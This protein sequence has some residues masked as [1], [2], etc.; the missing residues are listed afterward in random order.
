MDLKLENKLLLGANKL[1]LDIDKLRLSQLLSYMQLL[2]KWNK[3]YSLTAITDPEEVIT[4]HL[5][6][7]LT[8]VKYLNNAGFNMV[9][10][11][12]LDVGS[13]M[14]IPGIILA[15]CG[16]SVTVL[17]SNHKKTSFLS[18][19]KIELGLKNL[20]VVNA[21][22]ENYKHIDKFSIVTS[23][24]FAELKLFVDLTK[25]LLHDNGYFLAMK[26][27]KVVEELDKITGYSSEIIE[28]HIPETHDKRFLV[29]IKVDEQHSSNS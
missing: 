2:L 19:V 13:G 22:V 12:I 16:F 5:L 17:D 1:N 24:A 18:Q 21:R 14:G 6:D 15:I 23:R 10:N 3:V 27:Q 25:H 28:V 29:K 9:S 8:L 4:Y 20:T 11:T 7:G 26:S